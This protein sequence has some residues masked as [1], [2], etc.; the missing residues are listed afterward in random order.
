MVCAVREAVGRGGGG[1]ACMLDFIR[2]TFITANAGKT[3]KISRLAGGLLS[4]R[5]VPPSTVEC[6]E[7]V[8][9]VRLRVRFK[10]HIN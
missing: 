7:N 2:N 4:V 6:V 3:I 8:G 1:G 5:G 9:C 10:P